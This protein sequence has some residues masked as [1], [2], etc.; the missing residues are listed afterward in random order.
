[1]AANVRAE[2]AR[3]SIPQAVVAELLGITQQS[4]SARLSG[5]TDFSSSE[6]RA[7]ASLLGV[8]PGVLLR[9]ES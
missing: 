7:I 2:M 5:R 1:M 9:S 6:I 3:R 8:D 4:V